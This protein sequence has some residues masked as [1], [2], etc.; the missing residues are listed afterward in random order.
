MQIS[1]EN[2][3]ILLAFVYVTCWISHA[4]RTHDLLLNDRHIVRC[5]YLPVVPVI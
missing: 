4:R 5:F 1:D 2:V 3:G